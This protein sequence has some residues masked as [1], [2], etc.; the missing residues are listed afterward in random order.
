MSLFDIHVSPPSDATRTVPTL[1][2]LEAGTGHGA[3]TLHLSRAIHAANPPKP[4]DLE[5]PAISTTGDVDAAATSIAFSSEGIEMSSLSGLDASERFAQWKNERR[6]IIHTIDISAKFSKHAAKV[7]RG[8]RN[9][10]YASNV[11]FHVGD[12]SEWT[13]AQQLHRASLSGSDEAAPFLM[14]AFLDLPSTHDHLSTVASALHVNGT[15]VVFNPSITQIAEC[16]KQVKQ[17]ALPLFLDQVLELGNNGTS[18]GK[19]WDVRAVVPRAVAERLQSKG[20]PDGENLGAK[21]DTDG[22]G[23][24]TL[25][26]LVETPVVPEPPKDL[27]LV[28]RPKVGGMIVGGGFLGVFK[29]TRQD[30]PKSSGNQSD[31]VNTA[32]EE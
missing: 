27:T 1:E 20:S 12:V 10:I 21:V 29:K 18:G 19:E 23:D 8:F 28:C 3:L 32:Q 22:R 15:L 25:D 14:H 7:V 5:H 4:L 11:D 6:A 31:L 13:K 17:N 24:A 30:Q 9:G 2:I 16:V 26:A